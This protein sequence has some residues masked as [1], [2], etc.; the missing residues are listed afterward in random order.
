MFYAASGLL[1][2]NSMRLLD[3]LFH[4]NTRICGPV[5]DLVEEQ[6]EKGD[7]WNQYVPSFLYGIYLHDS[8][9]RIGNCDLRVGK[10]EELYYAGNIGYHIDP[11]YRGHHYALEACR[12]LFE[13]AEEKGMQEL[14]ITCSPENL[15]SKKTLEALPGSYVET[16]PVPPYHWLYQRG[17]KTKRIYRYRLGG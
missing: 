13:L 1:Y 6:V 4:R 7:A 14:I 16:V 10:N 11:C 3:W 2:N 8:P 9:R 5:V 17:E 12:L 15:P